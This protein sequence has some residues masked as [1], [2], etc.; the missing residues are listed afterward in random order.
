MP[1]SYFPSNYSLVDRLRQLWDVYLTPSLV[2]PKKV[3]KRNSMVNN[4]FDILFNYDGLS[5]LY[6]IYFH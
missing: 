2:L 4:L 3:S 6:L 5:N 1:N